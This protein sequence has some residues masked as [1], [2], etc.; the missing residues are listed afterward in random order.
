MKT[1]IEVKTPLVIETHGLSK[2]YK[3]VSALKSLDLK[4]P[5]HSIFGF[6][7][8]NGAGKTTTIKLLLGLARPTAGRGSIFGCD[9]VHQSGEIRRRIGY[10]AQDPRYYENMT[11]REILR[12]TLGFFFNG[13]K[14]KVEER[15]D[16]TIELVGLADKADRPVGGFSGGERQRLGIAQAQVNYPD[17]II[18]DEPAASLDP[19]GRH[20][21]LEVMERLRKHTTI[22]YSTHILD[23]V[24]RVS[25]KVCI[26]NHGELV[27]QAPIQ[28]LLAGNGQVSYHMQT[29]GDIQVIRSL[30]ASQ[31]WI[32]EVQMEQSDGQAHWQVSVSDAAI[33]EEQLLSLVVP[34]PG[35]RVIEYGKSK[36]EL[37][38]IFLNLVGGNNHGK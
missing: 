11:A 15:I 17:L 16:E 3:N 25:D 21:V 27:A 2:T 5:Q 26:L 14:G 22:F 38:D 7:G 18:L 20:D 31:P 12:F 13:P 35:I 34:V 28:E 36:F 33:A 29:R 23:D 8:P 6:L 10:L 4:V 24:Q 9:I 1:G 30:F 19:M 37:E 32:T